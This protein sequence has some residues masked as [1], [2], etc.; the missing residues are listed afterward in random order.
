MIKEEELNGVEE[1]LKFLQTHISALIYGNPYFSA[2][3]ARKSEM[4]L[5]NTIADIRT[6]YEYSK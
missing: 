4:Q 5:E 1:S 3:E 6:I 2:E